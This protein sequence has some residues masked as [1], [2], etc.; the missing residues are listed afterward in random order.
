MSTTT[1]PVTEPIDLQVRIGSGSVTIDA[2]DGLTEATV[3]VTT[4]HKGASDSLIVAMAGGTLVVSAPRQ[5][6]VFDLPILGGRHGKR[7]EYDVRVTVPAGTP[8]NVLT[9]TAPI[10]VRG[11]CGSADLAWGSTDATLEQVDGDLRLRFGNGSVHAEQ[12]SGT[13]EVRSGNGRTHLGEV[14]GAI[15][16]GSGSGNVDVGIA[17]DSVRLR[18]GS[19]SARIGAVHGDVDV[20]SG[21]GSVK[22]GLPAGVNARLDVTSGSGG[23]E[24]DL[25]IEDAPRDGKARAITVR[26]RAGSG[27][28][29]LFRAA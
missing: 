16:V 15:T 3:D 26:A 20:V 4:K 13:A 25:P 22:I 14:G 10:S 2:V 6:G 12:V 8:V 18:A 27:R 9:F 29:R 11:R 17:R 23:V 24:S 28:I 21:S 19:G 1:F 5:G 7:D